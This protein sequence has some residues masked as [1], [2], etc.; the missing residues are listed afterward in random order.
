LV[1]QIR[2]LINDQTSTRIPLAAIAREFYVSRFMVS[3]VFHRET[4]MRLR[5]YAL[6]LRLRRSLSLLLHTNIS[7]TD[8]AMELG[9]YDEPHFSKAFRNEFGMSPQSVRKYCTRSD[10]C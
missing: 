10:F 4:G 1:T 3:R 9:F 2:R 6:R 8:V 7:L 5:D